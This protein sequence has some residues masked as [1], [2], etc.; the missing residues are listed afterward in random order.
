MHKNCG[1]PHGTSFDHLFKFLQFSASIISQHPINK[2]YA[3]F[4]LFVRWLCVLVVY[5]IWGQG[6]SMFQ[7][8]LRQIKED[9]EKLIE[10]KRESAQDERKDEHGDTCKLNV[11]VWD[12]L[13]GRATPGFT[14]PKVRSAA[15]RKIISAKPGRTEKWNVCGGGVMCLWREEEQE[16]TLWRSMFGLSCM[17]N[18]THMKSTSRVQRLLSLHQIKPGTVWKTSDLG[19]QTHSEHAWPYCFH[20]KQLIISSDFVHF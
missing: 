7:H 2:C 16:K 11:S 20:T 14:Q 6:W 1:I 8:L 19:G 18:Y 4:T 13:I 10:W 9:Q 15:S 12:I 5:G 3:V 17:I